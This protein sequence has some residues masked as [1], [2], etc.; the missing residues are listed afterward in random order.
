MPKPLTRRWLAWRLV[1]LAHRI[2][3]AEYYERI[4]VNDG[5]GGLV[6]EAIICSDLYGGGVSSMYGAPG[7]EIPVGS[8]V[9][10]DDDYKPDWLTEVS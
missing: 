4:Y 6:F 1:Q 9:H 3:D 5:D 10:W 2:F 7:S 8:T